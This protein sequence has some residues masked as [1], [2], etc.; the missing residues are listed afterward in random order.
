MPVPY[1]DKLSMITLF[2]SDTVCKLD[3]VKDQ[4]AGHIKQLPAKVS[5]IGECS[6][7]LRYELRCDTINILTWLHN[8]KTNTKIYWSDRNNSFEV[9][10]IG[11]ADGL[12]SNGPINYKELFEYMEDHLSADNPRLRYYGGMSFDHTVCDKHWQEFGTYQFIIPQ[13]ELTQANKL[14]HLPLILQSR[15][16]YRSY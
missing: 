6:T 12:K 9:G 1:R 15:N 11:I 8:Q 16:Q 14:T 5:S 10:G 3:E 4:M 13:F 2:Q 7:V